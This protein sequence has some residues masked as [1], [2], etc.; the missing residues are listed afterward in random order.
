MKGSFGSSKFK[1]TYMLMLALEV[2]RNF[3]EFK[4][5]IEQLNTYSMEKLKYFD[6]DIRIKFLEDAKTG[7]MFGDI[8]NNY[9]GK[10]G[11][12]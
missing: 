11:E 6:E 7:L 3:E 2:S 9:F 10:P 5:N 1:S 8:L 4:T 12:D